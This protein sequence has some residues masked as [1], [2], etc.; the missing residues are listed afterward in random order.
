MAYVN[1]EG[2]RDPHADAARRVQAPRRGRDAAGAPAGRDKGGNRPVTWRVQ[3]GPTGKYQFTVK[4]GAGASQ[5]VPVEIKEA[6]F[7]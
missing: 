1:E 4:S 7:D 6:I 3:A 2:R 5:A